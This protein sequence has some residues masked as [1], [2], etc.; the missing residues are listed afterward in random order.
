MHA[1]EPPLQVRAVGCPVVVRQTVSAWSAVNDWPNASIPETTAQAQRPGSPRLPGPTAMSTAGAHP[2]AH[3]G[4][5][6][7]GAHRASPTLRLQPAR[8]LSCLSRDGPGPS[9]VYD[10]LQ[11]CRGNRLVGWVP[12]HLASKHSVLVALLVG[13]RTARIR[14]PPGV[15]RHEPEIAVAT[16]GPR[17]DPARRHAFHDPPS[18]AHGA[19]V[20][21]VRK[22]HH[23]DDRAP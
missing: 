13:D 19:G 4:H 3:R 22:V 15:L 14:A 1:A 11:G 2:R 9:G 17:S 20:D 5:V 10:G 16:R 12:T 6:G 8:D 23:R 7:H 21:V 18:P